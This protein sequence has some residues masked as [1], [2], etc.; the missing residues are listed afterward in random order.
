MEAA[1]FNLN[2]VVVSGTRWRQS[3]DNVPA[4]IISI[5]P[6]EVALQ[7]PQTAADLLGIS[8]QYSFKKANKEEEVP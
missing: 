2:E 3:S 4:K 1:D 5:S 7:N 8:G 6:Q